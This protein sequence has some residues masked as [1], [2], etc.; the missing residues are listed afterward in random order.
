MVDIKYPTGT[1]DGLIKPFADDPPMYSRT[2]AFGSFTGSNS[3]NIVWG[4]NSSANADY[5]DNHILI[6][7]IRIVNTDDDN[8]SRTIYFYHDNDAT[9][10]N[11]RV[12]KSLLF[13]IVLAGVHTDHVSSVINIEF[14]IPL[15][16]RNGCRITASGNGP[17]ADVCYTVLNNSNTLDW[18]TDLQYRYLTGASYGSS[19][20]ISVHPNFGTAAT[21]DTL[22]TA[23]DHVTGTYTKVALTGGTGYGAE[24]TV[25]VDSTGASGPPQL[26]AVS[27]VTIT[28]KGDGYTIDDTLTI[29]NATIG[30][31]ANAT[32][33]IASLTYITTDVQLWG[34]LGINLSD[35]NDDY[36]R[37]SIRNGGSSTRAIISLQMNTHFTTDQSAANTNTDG[38]VVWYPYPVHLKSGMQI[39]NDDS[40]LYSAWFYRPVKQ[41]GITY[42]QYGD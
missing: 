35:T 16:V 39:Y 36:S 13:Y 1:N 41:S 17:L 14:P 7:H 26:G 24:A 3:R 4:G 31:A 27:S 28:E 8:N 42:D 30:G 29:N 11:A 9:S 40:S 15:V 2:G 37:T 22:S 33:D 25:V 34:G 38:G 23:A 6:H 20:S 12:A 10:A 18:Y 32:C 19:G 21:V 5:E